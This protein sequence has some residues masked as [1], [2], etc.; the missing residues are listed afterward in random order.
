[1]GK[2][3]KRRKSGGKHPKYEGLEQRL[4]QVEREYASFTVGGQ[5]VTEVDG[6]RIADEPGITHIVAIED[7]VAITDPNANDRP[8][9]A[10]TIEQTG[11]RLS[12][13]NSYSF[14][15]SPHVIL[16]PLSQYDQWEL[17]QLGDDKLHKLS[18]IQLI[19]VLADLSPD[20]SRAL[21]D[22]LR[23][24]N[25]GYTITVFTK[26]DGV[27]DPVGQAMVENFIDSL[28]DM[29]GSADVVIGRLFMSAFLRGAMMAELVLDLD[30]RNMV[31]LAVPDP[32]S[33][34]FIRSE[35]PVRGIVW[36]LSQWQNRPD[37]DKNGEVV[38]GYVPLNWPTIRYVPIDP[39]PGV[40]YGRAIAAPALFSTLFLL[41]MLHD[42]RRVI[43]QQ[44]Y[45]RLDIS[46]SMDKIKAGMPNHVLNDSKAY[47]KWV[48]DTIKDI[49]VAYSRL[50]P[51]STFV[52]TDVAT[53]GR[54]IGTVD[55][56][57]L[58]AIDGLI[59]ALERMSTRALKTMPFMMASTQTTTETLAN[60]EWEVQTA[61]IKS[62]QSL[63]ATML[64]RL[65]SL[66]LQ[67]QGHPGYVTWE[68]AELRQTERQRDAQAEA[69]E[70]ANEQNKYAL[71][72]KDLDAVAQ[73]LEGHDADQK[74]PRY[75]PK[76]M[77]A[78]SDVNEPNADG[79]HRTAPELVKPDFGGVKPEAA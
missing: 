24:C 67:A 60:R 14:F 28:T 25:P 32:S 12:T 39:F 37:P 41:G 65:F 8:V 26:K 64:R 11:G 36:Q 45:P 48:N 49:Q 19:E 44:G 10:D 58:G 31:D 57:S 18:P 51:T 20:V 73:A 5:R 13:D 7:R 29:Y 4:A 34:R 63:A 33:I 71:G 22:F 77:V 15:G 16:P 75:V 52:H 66:G 69:I 27:P 68:F 21:W 3:H 38:A 46:V 56:S 61:G 35:D 9:A 54:P 62:I 53:L 30:H 42:L 78:I 79:T 70:I 40:P 6:D 1:M 17:I 76:T 59:Q 47:K 74:E 23:L 72:V 43:S 2:R 50:K 55:S